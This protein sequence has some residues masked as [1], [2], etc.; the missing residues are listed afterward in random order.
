MLTL[1]HHLAQLS[2]ELGDDPRS[3][4]QQLRGERHGFW[5]VL[6]VG[7]VKGVYMLDP[8]HLCGDPILDQAARLEREIQFRRES[9]EQ[10]SSEERRKSLALDNLMTTQRKLQLELSLDDDDT[11]GEDKPLQD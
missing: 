1:G 6:N 10:A 5:N 7:D 3:A 8:R 4:L 9:Y 2:I 11:E